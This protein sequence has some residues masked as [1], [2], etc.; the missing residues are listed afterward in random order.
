MRSQ[1]HPYFVELLSSLGWPVNVWRH[2]GWTGHVSTS[3]R[4]QDAPSEPPE[5]ADGPDGHG[6]AAFNG[7]HFVLYW[8]DATAELAFVVP[9]GNNVA[10]RRKTQAISEDGNLIPRHQN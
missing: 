8:A 1:V 2:A 10:A 3:W 5:W 4:V 6:G 7:N 9:S